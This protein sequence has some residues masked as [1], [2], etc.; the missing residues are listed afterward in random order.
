MSGSLSSGSHAEPN[1]TPILDMVFQLI[2]FF[3]LVCN[4]KA[5]SVAAGLTLP[6]VGSA[7]PVDTQG[8]VDL[9]V[10]NIDKQGNVIDFGNVRSDV[11]QYVKKQADASRRDAR[12]KQ[13]SIKV[14][15]EL[16]AMV[17]VRADR[18]TEFSKLNRVIKTC[19][20]QGY[21][22]Y[23]LKAKNKEEGA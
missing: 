15:D 18:A 14:G 20:E 12:K 3:M 17:V 2:T 13:P 7:R 4:F 23:A 16:P 6:V 21:R 9:V 11:E 22:N 10:M 5:A 1:M 8:S 19:I